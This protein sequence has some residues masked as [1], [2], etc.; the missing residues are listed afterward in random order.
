MEKL[1][2]FV[3]EIL[4]MDGTRLCLGMKFYLVGEDTYPGSIP[5]PP[6]QVDHRCGDI[7]RE[8]DLVWF[9][10]G[11]VLQHRV[12][13]GGG[14]VDQ[15]VAAKVRLFFVTLRIEPVGPSV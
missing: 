2:Q 15:D 9:F 4:M 3:I 6:Q 5:L 10:Y 12:I 14:I 11:W 7:D 13:H 8:G 1:L